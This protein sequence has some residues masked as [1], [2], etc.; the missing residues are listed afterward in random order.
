MLCKLPDYADLLV[1]QPLS[2]H[3]ITPFGYDEE[4]E[5]WE[6]DTVNLEVYLRKINDSKIL[7]EYFNNNK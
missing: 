7:K 1:Y 2:E 6:I 5:Y 3:T 4:D